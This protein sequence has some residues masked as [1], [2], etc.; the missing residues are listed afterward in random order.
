MDLLPEPHASAPPARGMGHSLRHRPFRRLFSSATV[1]TL[2]ASISLVSVNWIVFHYTHSAI[3]I[4]YLG[5]TGIAPG[6]V[7][8]V[9]AGVI[10]D[11]YNRRSLM[12]T[13][14]L[15]RFGGMAVLASALALAGF[16]LPL[17]L[18]VAVVINCFSAIFTPASQAILPRLVPNEALEDANGLLYSAN[19]VAASAGS[20]AGG[21]LVVLFGPVLGLGINAF[22]YALSATFLIQIA[23]ELGRAAGATAP[24]RR[25]F[26]HDLIEGFGYVR[27]HRPIL[28]VAFGYLPSNFLSAFVAPYFVVYSASRF[29]GSALAYGFLVGA[30]ALGTAIG[31]LLVGRVSTRRAAGWWMVLCLLGEGVAFG[32]LALTSSLPVATAAALADGL[33]IGFANT[34][35]Y[36][37]MQAIVPGPLL[38]RVLSIGDF[39]SFAAIPAGLVVGG[40]VIARYGIG[41]ALIVASIGVIV[42]AVVLLSLPDVRRFGAE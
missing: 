12:V 21:L 24:V 1:S 39:G 40:L 6:I 23:L 37:T 41:P 20:A 32:V 30:L 25:S 35:Y 17:I 5:L 16:S 8:G 18:A 42:T 38:A 34:V 14:D 29:G 28:E 31:G 33:S 7:L 10:A 26:G 36:A 11:R 19:G 13:A 9:F 3:D 27:Q 4:A 15:V 2:G 22:T